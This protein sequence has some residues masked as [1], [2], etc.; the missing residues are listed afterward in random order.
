[1]CTTPPL[2][3][4]THCPP[5]DIVRSEETNKKRVNTRLQN[6]VRERKNNY[7]NLD[8]GMREEALNH[9]L[10]V[11][12]RDDLLSTFLVVVRYL[13][14]MSKQAN[15]DFYVFKKY[16]PSS[17]KLYNRTHTFLNLTT[18]TNL[19]NNISNKCKSKTFQFGMV[20]ISQEKGFK[21]LR[22][23]MVELETPDESKVSTMAV[24]NSKKRKESVSQERRS[25]RNRK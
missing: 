8:L 25:K 18:P 21:T 1:M 13:F 3:R 17:A 19:N 7:E 15:Q 2:P 20:G 12:V 5:K 6:E 16:S 22:E 9:H 24:V 11:L 23:L 10:E 14:D 4:L